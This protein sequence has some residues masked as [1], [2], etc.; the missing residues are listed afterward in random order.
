MREP[1]PETHDPSLVERYSGKWVMPEHPHGM[2]NFDFCYHETCML[3]SKI[4]IFGGMPYRDAVYALDLTHRRWEVFHDNVPLSFRRSHLCAAAIHNEKL[5]ALG[6]VA[7]NVRQTD[8]F[9]FDLILKEFNTEP[10]VGDSLG[11]RWGSSGNFCEASSDFVVFGGLDTGDTMCN[12]VAVLGLDSMRWRKPVIKGRPPPPRKTH[13]AFAQGDRL[14]IYGGSTMEQG[15]FLDD[16]YCLVVGK[17]RCTWSSLSFS[18]PTPNRQFRAEMAVVG[19]RL[20]LVGG[21]R[22]HQPLLLLSIADMSTEKWL[23]MASERDGGAQPY[24]AY[25][26]G[27][28]QSLVAHTLVVTGAKDIICLGG[29]RSGSYA[30]Y[31]LQRVRQ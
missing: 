23:R 1:A 5:Y 15:E 24:D 7:S 11:W 9:S 6:G 13:S 19:D 30:V 26:T 2:S 28:G 18:G 17:E 8:V 29:A 25:V 21:M 22:E 12:D 20:F 27:A 14:F 4:I 3:S 31:R 16:L 10:T